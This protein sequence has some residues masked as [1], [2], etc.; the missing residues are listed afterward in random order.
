[1]I[2]TILKMVQNKQQVQVQ[3]MCSIHLQHTY[4][5]IYAMQ[6]KLVCVQRD[7][8]INNDNEKANMLLMRNW[9]IAISYN[10]SVLRLHFSFYLTRT[11]TSSYRLGRRDSRCRHNTSRCGKRHPTQNAVR[12]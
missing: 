3:R 5:R 11:R 8:C 6:Q 12:R 10:I 7:I 1:M 4:H 9:N 2:R